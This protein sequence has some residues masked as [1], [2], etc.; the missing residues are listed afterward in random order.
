MNIVSHFLKG[1]NPYSRSEGSFTLLPTDIPEES[2][3]NHKS[4]KRWESKLPQDVRENFRPLVEERV[5]TWKRVHVYAPLSRLMDYLVQGKYMTEDFIRQENPT[6]DPSCNLTLAM[7]NPVIQYGGYH[8]S[9]CDLT[10]VKTSQ[11][12]K[13][14]FSI[15]KQHSELDSKSRLVALAAEG[16]HLFALRSD[17]LVIQWDYKKKIE[18]NQIE[19]AYYQKKSPHVAH[20]TEVSYTYDSLSVI[21]EVVVVKYWASWQTIIELIPYS[22]PE[23]S[24]LITESSDSNYLSRL[25]IKGDKLFLKNQNNINSWNLSAK[26]YDSIQ[27]NLVSV[28]GSKI[29]AM[30]RDK[31]FLYLYADSKIYPFDL[32]K[33]KFVLRSPKT[34]EMEEETQ[35]IIK[36]EVIDGLFFGLKRAYSTPAGNEWISI[37]N[38]RTNK[39]IRLISTINDFQA[40]LREAVLR[41]VVEIGETHL[42][43]RK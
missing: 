14:E 32:K 35:G 21:N 25:F 42:N 11:E 9:I 38:L 18:V 28:E 22:S 15:L 37:K 20:L 29:S 26:K 36:F 34:K 17:G 5:L 30:A 33:H 31:E 1:I 43:Q 23:D 4:D 3:K 2:P 27:L 12:G 40:V 41:E 16:D 7:P 10:S 6:L 24:K 39:D 8:F 13:S 19:T